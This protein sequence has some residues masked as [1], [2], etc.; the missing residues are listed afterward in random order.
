MQKNYNT[1][2]KFAR[3]MFRKKTKIILNIYSLSQLLNSH[4]ALHRNNPIILSQ[5]VSGFVN[6]QCVNVKFDDF[7]DFVDKPVLVRAYRNR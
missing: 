2:S 6:I 7:L 4:V 1:A 5:K 3:E